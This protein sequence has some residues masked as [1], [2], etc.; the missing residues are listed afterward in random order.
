MAA[1]RRRDNIVVAFVAL[2]AIVGGGHAVLDA[3]ATAPPGPSD[4]STISLLGRSQL[5]ESF[6][7]EFVVTYLGSAAGQQDRIAEFVGD[8]QHITLPA[9]ARQVTDPVVVF[10]TRTTSAGALDVW[11]VTVSVRVAKRAGAAEEARQYYRVGVSV[12]DGRLRAL[13]L[14]AAVEPPGRGVDL[15][16][17]YSNSCAAD[18]PLAQV[19]A[20][21]VQAMLTGTG[22]IA[23]YTTPDSGITALRPAPFST[24]ETTAVTSDDSGCGSGASSARVLAS[25]DP[26]AD[27]AAAP[28]LS[29]PLDMVRVAGQWQVRALEA[30]PAL[31]DPMTVSGG[32]AAHD[33]TTAPSGTTPTTPAA[34]VQIPP[35]TQK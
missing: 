31:H 4:K 23:R 21:F 11:A 15:V 30:V 10:A 19:A 27:G 3:F 8:T 14:P 13:G 7:R 35:A 17:A 29:Y 26:K 1:R 2:S 5:A 22:D 25:V 28:T 24:V 32:T 33:T 16:S 9:T 18:T 12:L 6:A 34:A 20:G